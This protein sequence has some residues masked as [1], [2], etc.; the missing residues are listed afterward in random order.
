M[1]AIKQHKRQ[2]YR[3]NRLTWTWVIV[4]GG[5]VSTERSLKIV[6]TAAL[7]NGLRRIMRV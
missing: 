3:V 4:N 6:N 1:Q 2:Q 7:Q 5:N